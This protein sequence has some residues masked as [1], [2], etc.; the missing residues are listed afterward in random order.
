MGE[1]NSSS[2]YSNS[3]IDSNNNMFNNNNINIDGTA[4]TNNSNSNL[5]FYYYYYSPIYLWKT[6][7]KEIVQYSQ[8]QK[9]D[10]RF[11]LK[12]RTE[13]LLSKISN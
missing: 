12:E 5:L 8:N 6:H 1:Y 13:F 10:P 9:F 2:R 11:V 3:N 4:F 7:F